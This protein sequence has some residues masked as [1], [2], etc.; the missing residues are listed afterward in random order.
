MG[1]ATVLMILLSADDVLLYSS[2]PVVESVSSVLAHVWHLSDSRS[3]SRSTFFTMPPN[4]SSASL[5]SLAKSTPLTFR[6]SNCPATPPTPSL[7]T[8]LYC[9]SAIFCADWMAEVAVDHQDEPHPPPPAAAAWSCA[10]ELGMFVGGAAT[11]AVASSVFF[12]ATD[13][14]VGLD[15]EDCGTVSGC[16][17]VLICASRKASALAASSSSAGL[18]FVSPAAAGV[19]VRAGRAESVD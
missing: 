19:S 12:P 14:V 18:V 4:L 15:E 6:C 1:G 8:F 2:C 5:R 9:S 11:L 10:E 7:F 3:F 13:G 17:F 16:R